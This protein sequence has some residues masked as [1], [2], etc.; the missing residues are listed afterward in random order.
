MT[1]DEAMVAV[2][3]DTQV[4]CKAEVE[5]E[6]QKFAVRETPRKRSRKWILCLRGSLCGGWSRIRRRNR[7]G[8]HW[9]ARDTR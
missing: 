6:G 5:L 8:R 4:E 2:R 1:L 9:G 3:R 7:A